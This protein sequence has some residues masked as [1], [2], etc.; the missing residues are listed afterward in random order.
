MIKRNKTLD[1]LKGVLIVL[2]VLGHVNTSNKYIFFFQEVAYIFHMPLFFV[3]GVYYLKTESVKKGLRASLLLLA[4][5]AFFVCL[6]K[7]DLKLAALSIL[8]S[9]YRTLNSILWFIPALVTLRSLVFIGL[10]FNAVN[11]MITTFSIV[12]ILNKQMVSPNSAFRFW[13]LNVAI[14]LYPIAFSQYKLF[15][16]L[17]GKT[18]N[19]RIENIRMAP[20]LLILFLVFVSIFYV[21][22]PIQNV[23]GFPNRLDLAQYNVPNVEGYLYLLII[24]A[25]ATAFACSKIRIPVFEGIG[26]ASLAIYLLHL[27]VIK[28]INKFVPKTLDGSIISV[29]VNVALA[30]LLCRIAAIFFQWT[31]SLCLRKIK[32]IKM[33]YLV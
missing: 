8:V 3:V 25:I 2:V 12:A 29:G 10:R 18:E 6:L 24:S 30:V 13:G 28:A 7:R 4:I 9:D 20:W 1:A 26:K 33:N 32:L 16:I 31:V 11:W 5:Y 27:P 19:E 15:H 23:S 22:V 17:S 14:Y 21:R